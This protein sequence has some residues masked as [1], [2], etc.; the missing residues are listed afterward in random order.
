MSKLVHVTG[1]VTAA[2]LGGFLL[3]WGSACKRGTFKRNPILSVRTLTTLRSDQA[4]ITA[5]RAG[6]P[7]L[8]TAGCGV[9]AAALI[10]GALTLLLNPNPATPLTLTLALIWALAWSTGSGILA[11]RATRAFSTTPPPQETA[12]TGTVQIHRHTGPRPRI[13]QDRATAMSTAARTATPPKFRDLA[14]RTHGWASPPPS[15]HP[16][17]ASYAR[18]N[19]TGG[20]LPH[21]WRSIFLTLKVITGSR[22][23]C[24]P[25][26]YHNTHSRA[27]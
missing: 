12:E 8:T 21:H 20:A 5:H 1:I 22:G 18:S 26:I 3:W 4:W 13:T 15:G 27:G 9:L 23:P 19:H 25:I 17:G 24:G 2:I 10:V 11:I 7:Q 16:P 14:A 6:E